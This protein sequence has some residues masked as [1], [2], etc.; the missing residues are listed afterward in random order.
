MG[1]DQV[2]PV[3]KATEYGNRLIGPY[4]AAMPCTAA[5]TPELFAIPGSHDWYDGLLNF[6][7]VFCRG[8]SIGAWQTSQTRSYFALKLPHRWWL[9]GVDM[10]FGDY[11]R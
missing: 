11:R 1:G 4:R 5:E 6:T 2:Y 8:R 10:Q 9:W 3:P 7:N